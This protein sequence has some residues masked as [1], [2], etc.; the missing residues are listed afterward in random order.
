MALLNSGC[1][2]VY[3]HV[4]APDEC[5]HQGDAH[6]KVRA[7]EHIDK[8]VLGRI[9]PEMERRGEEYSVL[10][11]PDHPTPLALRTHTGEPVPFVLWRSAGPVTSGISRYCEAD[12]RKTGLIVKDGHTLMDMFI[13]KPGRS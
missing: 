7:I 3:I 8:E 5:G 11:M 6:G 10:L 2:F 9:L 4:E 12:A 13:K 1:D